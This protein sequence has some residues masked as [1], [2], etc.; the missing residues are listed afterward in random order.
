MFAAVFTV[1]EWLSP[2]GF[3]VDLG[4]WGR[5]NLVQL[6]VVAS[7]IAMFW[8]TP[9]WAIAHWRRVTTRA[10]VGLAGLVVSV[11]TF[12]LYRSAAQNWPGGLE[13]FTPGGLLGILA[14]CLSFGAVA[15]V[16]VAVIWAIAYP[17]KL[18][19]HAL[20]TQLKAFD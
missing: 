7:L 15:S 4:E 18:N 12:S 16:T 10:A 2:S 17:R 19:E 1:T 5:P 11:M 6:A 9:L 3:P 13:G 8:L 20:E 14:V